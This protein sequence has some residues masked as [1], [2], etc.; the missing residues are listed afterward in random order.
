MKRNRVANEEHESES[1]SERREE[2]DAIVR[3]GGETKK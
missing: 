1:E 2:T 3:S